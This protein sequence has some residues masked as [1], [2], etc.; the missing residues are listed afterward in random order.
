MLRHG[1]EPINQS[2][3]KDN[4]ASAATPSAVGAR[5]VGTDE[6][7][8]RSTSAVQ[9]APSALSHPSKARWSIAPALTGLARAPTGV[10]NASGGGRE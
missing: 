8:Q 2:I 9:A 3:S 5:V 1:A 6:H 10:T 7:R 4:T